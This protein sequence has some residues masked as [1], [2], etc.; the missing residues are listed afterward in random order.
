[1]E[2]IARV[3]VGKRH[4]KNLNHVKG[5]MKHAARCG[6]TREMLEQTRERAIQTAYQ[7]DAT[8]VARLRALSFPD[9]W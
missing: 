1:M 5:A 8:R 9:M 3:Y 2:G 4:T 7:P 6:A